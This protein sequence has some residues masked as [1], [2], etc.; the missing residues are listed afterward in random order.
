MTEH[1]TEQISLDT[2]SGSRF[3]SKYPSEQ[4]LRARHENRF[5]LRR[6]NA[7]KPAVTVFV[8]KP[9]TLVVDMHEV[10]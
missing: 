9:Y 10:L 8:Q 4:A 1:I 3:V 6:T 2:I 7:V 5:D